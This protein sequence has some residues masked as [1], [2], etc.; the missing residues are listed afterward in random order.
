MQNQTFIG[1]D[2]GGT[3]TKF[4]RVTNGRIIEEVCLATRAAGSENDV[5]DDIIM[6]INR[7]MSPE[8]SGIG[9]GAPGLIDKSNGIVYYVTNIP[10]W[11]EVYLKKKLETQF[12]I[13][14]F[15]S[16]D[17]NCFALG[18]KYYGKGQNFKDLVCLSLGTG[19]GSGII[20]NDLLYTGSYNIAGEFGCLPYL[21]HNFE[22]YCSGE[23]F[24][25]CHGFTGREFYQKALSGDINAIKV[26]DQYGD[27]LGDLL[28]TILYILGPEAIIIGG[29]VAQSYRFFQK[30]MMEKLN[31]FPFK[32]VINQLTVEISK[33]QSIAVI[34]AAALCQLN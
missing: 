2:L 15:I 28:Q 3:K 26:F 31:K 21:K 6:G 22:Y 7:V 1:V 29:S 32:H 24:K 10:S 9:I 12:G 19:V 20:V 5:I 4:G 17:A 30:A 8:V 34:G 18:E 33:N 11:K 23:F 13:K 16:N 25:K 27:H 14:V